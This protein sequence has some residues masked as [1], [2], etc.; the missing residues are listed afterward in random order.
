MWPYAYGPVTIPTRPREIYS[1]P[2]RTP[3]YPIDRREYNA[4]ISNPPNALHQITAS[5]TGWGCNNV[6]NHPAT[7]CWVGHEAMGQTLTFTY[8]R[9][10]R[11]TPIRSQRNRDFTLT[12]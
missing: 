1:T 3:P 7:A 10:I 2:A 9:R 8:T 4:K 11:P 12:T 6:Y 5:P